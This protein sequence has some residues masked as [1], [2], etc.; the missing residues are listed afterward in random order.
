MTFTLGDSD[1]QCKALGLVRTFSFG[2]NHALPVEICAGLGFVASCF[3]GAFARMRCSQGI[4]T[5]MPSLWRV[6]LQD[7]T[8]TFV[9]AFARMRLVGGQTKRQEDFR[10]FTATHLPAFIFNNDQAGRRAVATIQALRD[11]QSSKSAQQTVGESQTIV[12][13]TLLN[14]RRQRASP[15][16]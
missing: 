11:A 14:V 9:G 10:S 6:S 1:G 5:P 3:A 7:V 4:A 16:K 8:R 12:C 15:V 13:F 2:Q